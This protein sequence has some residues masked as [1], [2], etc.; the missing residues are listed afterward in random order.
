MITE[1]L[2]GMDIE[3]QIALRARVKAALDEQRP[4]RAGLAGIT[5][6]SLRHIAASYL[7]MRGA[8]I[9]TVAEIMGHANIA[10]TSRY[11]H[12]LDAHRLA[13]IDRLDGLGG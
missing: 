11:T 1:R 5:L 3:A 7:V 8:D 12:L 13:A 10:T 9:R 6:Y 2:E 4:R